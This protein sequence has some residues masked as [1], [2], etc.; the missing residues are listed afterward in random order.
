MAFSKESAVNAIEEAEEVERSVVRRTEVERSFFHM[1]KR[2]NTENTLPAD[3][4]PLL[5]DNEDHAVGDTI[6]TS[7]DYKKL[8]NEDMDMK[9]SRK[10]ALVSGIKSRFA[11]KSGDEEQTED[12][13]PTVSSDANA[14]GIKSATATTGGPNKLLLIG[15]AILLLGGGVVIG[16]K[17]SHVAAPAPSVAEHAPSMWN[18]PQEEVL[19]HNLSIANH[20]M[21]LVEH[22]RGKGAVSVPGTTTKAC[23]LWI[24]AG[25][26]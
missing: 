15:A 18:S 14:S 10:D 5:P 21:K 9:A 24:P 22:C 1:R 8:T 4:V 25:G 7:K 12:L 16:K 3:E 23:F 19:Y 6:D 20:G 26:M 17:T 11:K 13:Q 2:N